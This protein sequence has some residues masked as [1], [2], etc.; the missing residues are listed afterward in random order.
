PHLPTRRPTSP[1]SCPTSLTRSSTSPTRCP[2]FLTR[3]PTS[4]TRCPT[5]PADCPT[6][7]TRCPTFPADS[8][9]SPT[10]CPTSPADCP[11]SLTRCPTFPTRCP[12]SAANCPTSP[13]DCPTS[14]A[15]C[16]T[17][18]ADCPSSPTSTRFKQKRVYADI[19]SPSFTKSRPA[20]PSM[21]LDQPVKKSLQDSSCTAST[22]L[23]PVIGRTPGK[24]WSQPN[25]N[26]LSP[27]ST[28]ILAGESPD[29][30]MD[31]FEA[32][33]AT[34]S[35]PTPYMFSLPSDPPLSLRSDEMDVDAWPRTTGASQADLEADSLTATEW[36]GRDGVEMDAEEHN[37]ISRED[38][39]CVCP[40]QLRKLRPLMSG[41]VPEL[42][43]KKEHDGGLGD[44]EPLSQHSLSLV[45]STKE[46]SYT[47]G[48]L[49]LLSDLLQPRFYPPVDITKHLLRD[50]LLD[51]LCSDVLCLQ[52]Y[53]LLMRTQRHKHTDI[54]TVPWDWE[55]L[56][57]VMAKE[58]S[59]S[60]RLS[61]EVVRMLLHYVVQ[62]MED[63]FRV[64]LS[65]RNLHNSITKATV[66]CS[67]R[68]NQVR[69]V[70]IW[71]F[72]A[73]VR[74]TGDN[75]NVSPDL[76]MKT[77]KELRKIVILLQK[78]ISLALEVD[79]SPAL[80]SSKLSGEL[81][82]MVTST[83]PLREHRL[84]L[85]QTLESQLLR[86]KLTEHLLHDA[87]PKKT[88]LPMSLSLLLHFLQNATLTPDP[89]EGAQSW[90]KWEEL[91][92]LLW[93]LLLSYE[94]V[95]NG[96]LR[97][98]VSERMANSRIPIPN[99]NDIVSPLAVQ[100]AVE[101]FLSRA[102]DDIRQDLPQH[103]HESLTYLQDHLL[104]SAQ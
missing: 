93:M 73:I 49:Q 83:L 36:D 23:G 32:D 9:T 37:V 41:P 62:T 65:I 88:P 64:K 51:P 43:A 104:A 6:S 39:R 44:L 71:L 15:N 16:P 58:L 82:H 96:H 18:P 100:E 13:P 48:T 57:S 70:I 67:L 72:A 30:Q 40:I 59:N 21:E 19:S 53:S 60:K 11:T 8:P 31:E 47:E 66:S 3:H 2:T 1:T 92:Q 34:F 91:V 78:M 28:V 22:S 79:L 102:Q 75:G 95:T 27:T 14:P 87:S 5:S 56:T 81:F 76:K 35:P 94:E 98:S 20:S 7:P 63:D 85:L 42:E 69:D 101:S 54:N 24:N 86:C 84:L 90:K 99:T 68:F 103:I 89:T 4:P 26:T 61:W 97:F 25:R 12:T 46:E 74:S 17:S 10:R 52:A 29:W 55:L 50:I 77:H 80:N 45:N 33:L 38:K